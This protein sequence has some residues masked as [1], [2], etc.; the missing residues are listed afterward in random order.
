MFKKILMTAA[1]FAL[2][3]FGSQSMAHC[4]G[5]G[6]EDNHGGKAVDAAHAE[7]KHMA[8]PDIVDTAAA[9][10]DFSTLVAAVKAADLVD[11]LKGDGPFTV[12]APTNA[13]FEALPAGTLDNLLK[14]ENKEQLQGILKYHV[15]SGKIMAGDIANGTTAVDTLQGTSVDVAK[16]ATGV[17]VDGANVT[18][19]DIKTSNG[20]IHVIDAVILP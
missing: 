12:F 18:A 8:K 19:A 6:E 15:V 14:P 1:A 5:C 16:G 9:N 2:L 11:A 17:S 13:A 10:A 20:V 4:G 7:A 3:G